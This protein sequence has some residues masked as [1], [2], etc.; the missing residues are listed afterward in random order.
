[1][2][3]FDFLKWSRRSNLI[4]HRRVKTGIF[5]TF[6][7]VLLITMVQPIPSMKTEIYLNIPD[8]EWD[9]T[10]PDRRVGWCA[11]ACIQMAM[12][13]YGHHISQSEINKA[14]KP[15]HSDLYMDDIDPALNQLSVRYI[16][17]NPSNSNIKMLVSWIKEMLDLRYPVLCGVKTYPDKH[18]RWF[19][20]HFVLI[21]GY[22][23]KGFIVNTNMYGQK[24]ISF[25][26]ITSSK[27]G[28]SFK[29]KYNKYFARAIT[30][31]DSK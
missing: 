26:R 19:L 17:W 4:T 28:F 10:R 14:G 13:F 21:V 24:E 29:N 1:M 6:S 22:N 25:R 31:V 23:D 12:A 5:Y 3:R 20:D 27:S 15:E 11:E 8:R 2:K 30:G 7:L 9:N 16:T 18:P